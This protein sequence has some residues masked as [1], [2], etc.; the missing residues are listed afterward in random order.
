MTKL[1]PQLVSCTF[2]SIQEGHTPLFWASHLG[3]TDVVK[4]LLLHG[5]NVNQQNDVSRIVCDKTI[6][7]S[8]PAIPPIG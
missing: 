6:H 4:T 5:A 2:L 8:D 7:E 1:T 3:H